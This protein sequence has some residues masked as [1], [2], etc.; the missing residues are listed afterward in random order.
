MELEQRFQ[1]VLREKPPNVVNIP[2]VG[3]AVV[4]SAVG[5]AVVGSAVFVKFTN[6][7]MTEMRKRRELH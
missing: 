5:S 4:G 7:E 6:C 2:I 3:S 1:G